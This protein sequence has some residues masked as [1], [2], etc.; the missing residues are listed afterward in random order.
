MQ[1]WGSIRLGEKQDAGTRPGV[2]RP[3]LDPSDLRSEFDIF[4]EMYCQ[5]SSWL[6]D[7]QTCRL[8]PGKPKRKKENNF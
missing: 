6:S 2:M 5:Y 3:V 7:F 4:N 1:L 8:F